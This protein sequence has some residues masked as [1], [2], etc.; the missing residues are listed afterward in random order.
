M[1]PRDQDDEDARLSRAKIITSPPPV[2]RTPLVMQIQ[3]LQA[4]IIGRSSVALDA[5]RGLSDFSPQ[6]QAKFAS[7]FYDFRVK[8]H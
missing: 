5:F 2:F 3:I 8:S 4:C 7:I 1:K 6:K